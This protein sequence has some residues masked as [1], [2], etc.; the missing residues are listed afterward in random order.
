MA[1]SKDDDIEEENENFPLF[2]TS[3]TPV[4]VVGYL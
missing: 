3:L 2:K 1:C 4:F